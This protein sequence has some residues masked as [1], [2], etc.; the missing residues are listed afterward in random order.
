MSKLQRLKQV[1]EVQIKYS[2]HCNNQGDKQQR[3]A[4]K[5]DPDQAKRRTAL[6][7]KG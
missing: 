3:K 5:R 6:Q 1:E 4:A 2:N 7:R